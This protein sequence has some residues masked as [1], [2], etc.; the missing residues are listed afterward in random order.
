MRLT[1]RQGLVLS[2]AALAAPFI[3]PARAQGG[4]VNVYNWADYIGETTIADFEAATGITVVYDLYPSSEEMEAKMLAGASGYDVVLQSGLGLPRMLEAGVYRPLDKSKLQGLD[5]LD[6]LIL[7]IMEGWDPGNAH[8]LPYMWGSVGFTFN[9]DMVKERLPDADLENLDTLFLPANAEKLADCGISILDSPTDIML[10]VLRYLGLDGDTENLAD[11]DRVA[12]AFA[13]IRPHIRT[14]DNANYLNAIPN[15][16]LCVINTWSGDYSVARARAAE[17]GI[18]LNLAYHVPKTG[19]PI[20]TDGWAIPADAPN[21]DNAYAF[22]NWM[23]RPEVVA[24]A[25][26]YTGY[27]NANDAATALVDEAIRSDPAV[28][29]T[30][31][32]MQ[33]LWA[34]QPL[35]EDQDRALMRAWAAIKAG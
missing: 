27:A 2:T 1:R 13:G 34:P 6:G 32:V 16:E 23:L 15:G 3:R 17:A 29:P 12:E 25:T 20:W 33:R 22:L 8:L 21:P 35:N 19:A 26:D 28:Y 5:N 14:F 30:P 11:Y 10:I 31:E 4:T 7:A 18:A 24:A 9:L